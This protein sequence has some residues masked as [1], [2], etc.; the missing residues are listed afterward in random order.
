MPH[1]LLVGCGFVGERTADLFHAAGWRVTAWTA[2]V[3]SAERLA[4]KPYP[5]AAQDI[6]DGTSLAGARD[7]MTS[8]DLLVD[9][10]SSG[11]GGPEAYRR[12][13]LEGARALLGIFPQARFIFTG[14]TSVYAQT[15]GSWVDE[16][17][18]AEPDRETGRILR[19]TENLV[20]DH[21]GATARLAGL[22]GPGR[23]VLLRKFLDGEGVIEGDGL[24]WI[25]FCHRDDAAGA[26]FA[27]G[28]AATLVPG[29]YNVAD[30]TPLTQLECYRALAMAAGRSLPPF[31]PVDLG[32]KRGWTSKRVS[33][34]RM[35]ALMAWKP[36]VPSF[37]AWAAEEIDRQPPLQP[38]PANHPA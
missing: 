36:L 11:R 27:L 15:D 23:S 38:V 22:Y 20:T 19:E 2:S 14:S 26:L 10:V 35:R 12:V 28:T 31:G 9:C 24:R 21:G 17:S 13:Y 37:T 29:V 16:A 7:G 3:E 33:N 18:P 25:N 32:R 5:V 30:D 8:V 4:S 34:A 1:L 6:A